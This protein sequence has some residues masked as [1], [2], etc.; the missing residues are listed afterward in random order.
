MAITIT[1]ETSQRFDAATDFTKAFASN[2]AANSLVVVMVWSSSATAF[3]AGDCTKSAGTATIGAVSLDK[4]NDFDV[5]SGEI[6][7]AAIWSFLVT[8]AGSLTVNVAVP[9]G[10]Y[11]TI[12]IGEYG[13]SWDSSRLEASAVGQSA[14]DGSSAADTANMTSAGA[15]LFVGTV[16]VMGSDSST[17]CTANSPW[18]N[19]ASENDNTVHQAGAAARN[20][21]ASGTTDTAG[22]TINVSGVSNRGYTAVGAVYKEAAGG[23]G[24]VNTQ[25]L[26]DTLTITDLGIGSAVRGRLASDTILVT[27]GALISSTEYGLVGDDTIDVSDSGTQYAVRARV[28]EDAL[29]VTDQAL[30]F[31]LRHYVLQDGIS[32]TDELIASIIAGN[33][34]IFTSV[35]TS[36]LLLSDELLPYVYR[37]RLLQSD[38]SVLDEAILWLV[39]VRGL[40]SFVEVTDQNLTAMK[41]FILLTDVLSVD[42]SLVSLYV[43]DGVFSP[44]PVVG[45]DPPKI[46]VGSDPPHIVLGGLAI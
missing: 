43:P 42:D 6:A 7:N 35:L 19:I 36:Q 31:L 1:Q 5:G 13:G 2:V 28:A 37:N 44:R 18:T 40:D 27:E 30:W 20:N 39:R 22:W 17:T 9:D 21:F 11:G 34:T 41:R 33:N 46:V 15:A 25:T 4:E 3:V 32:V 23:G 38:F 26:T 29:T 8:G 45:V 14:T 12:V 10:S 16:C 24:T